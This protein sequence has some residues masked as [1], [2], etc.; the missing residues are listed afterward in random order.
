[1]YMVKEQLEEKLREIDQIVN[2]EISNL[3]SIGVL[4]GLSGV[5]LFHFYYSKYLNDSKYVDKGS[6]V[7]MDCVNKINNGFSQLT[8]CNGISG[9][10]WVLDH[11]KQ[12]QFIEIDTDSL[13]TQFDDH[14]KELMLTD[15][16]NENYE[17]L[18]GAVGNAY[19]F[20]NRYKNTQSTSL[21]ENYKNILLEF[22]SELLSTATKV[23]NDKIVWRSVLNPKINIKGYNL[24]LAHGVSG[25]I[26]IL[27]KLHAYD[28]FK[29]VTELLLSQAINYILSCKNKDASAFSF[30]P[31]SISNTKKGIGKSRL[32]WCYGDLGIGSMLWNASIVLNDNELKKEALTVLRHAAKRKTEEQTWVND[33]MICHGAFGNALL[34][35]RIYKNTKEEL[36]KETANFWFETGINMIHYEKDDYH[37]QDWKIKKNNW[38]SSSSL[39]EGAAGIGLII[40][41]FLADFDSNWDEC[42]LIH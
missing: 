31:N 34:F 13:L 4:A 42:L 11:L 23:G 22:L 5:S 6:E 40:V 30:F 15:L 36:F 18:Y 17:F 8:Y 32:A 7:L 1:M 37:V 28:D 20:L 26:G 2:T 41:D 29:N 25:I 10:G 12:E 35:K 27:S 19:Y 14:L 21:K 33:A 9:F 3:N 24:G 38:N 39:I 16:K